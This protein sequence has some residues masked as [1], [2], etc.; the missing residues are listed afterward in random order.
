MKNI[1]RHTG[2]LKIIR[3]LNSSYNGNPRYL[4]SI[5][6]FNCRTQVD[7]MHGYAITNYDNCEVTATIGTHYKNATLN[8]LNKKG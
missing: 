1:T 5:D 3:R 4:L 2:T 7:S 6:G 8:T